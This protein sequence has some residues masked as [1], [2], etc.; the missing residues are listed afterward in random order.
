MPAACWARPVVGESRDLQRRPVSEDAERRERPAQN[1]RRA[2]GARCRAQV[3][4]APWPFS[5]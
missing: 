2:G 4:I 3:L 5:V 1:P